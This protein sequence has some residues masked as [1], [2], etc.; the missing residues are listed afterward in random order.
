MKVLVWEAVPAR[1]GVANHS[2]SSI[3]AFIASGAHPT[4]DTYTH[5]IACAVHMLC[6]INYDQ[7]QTETYIEQAS[8]Y[9]CQAKRIGEG[10]SEKS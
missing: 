2:R 1:T 5:R 4:A 10:R 8:N 7:M 9:Y 3:D 6:R